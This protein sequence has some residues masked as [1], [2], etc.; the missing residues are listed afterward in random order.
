MV[1]YEPT[2]MSEFIRTSICE[3]GRGPLLNQT[4]PDGSGILAHNMELDA[5]MPFGINS[6]DGCQAFPQ[7]PND[8]VSGIA[9]GF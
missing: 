5:V 8:A 2:Q 7:A 1:I 3:E 4:P 6:K 9:E